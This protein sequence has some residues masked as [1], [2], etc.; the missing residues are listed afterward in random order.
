M[1]EPVLDFLLTFAGFFYWPLLYIRL[2]DTFFRCDLTRK[3]IAGS[4]VFAVVV[5]LVLVSSGYVNYQ[6]F[7][8]LFMIG[9]AFISV[10]I[11]LMLPKASS[12]R[13]KIKVAILAMYFH[14][15]WQMLPVINA[16]LAILE[17][18][19]TV[20]VVFTAKLRFRKHA[21]LHDVTLR[22]SSVSKLW[23]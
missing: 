21:R 17:I 1:A 3:K 15:A 13:T 16:T 22:E 7:Y 9:L 12:H 11:L 19:V 10:A 4:F 8:F 14:V 5:S 20:I 2:R 23:E 6:T 18:V